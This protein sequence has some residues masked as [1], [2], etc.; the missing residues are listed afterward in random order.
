MLVRAAVTERPR[1]VEVHEFPMPEPAP[2]AVLMEVRYSGICGTD[3]HTFRGESKQYAGTAQR[4]RPD[5]PANLRARERRTG[6]CDWRG[7]AGRR[8]PAAQGRRPN[9]SWRKRSVRQPATSVA[10]GIP[11]IS[12]SALK[13]MGTVCIARPR[14]ICSGA[15]PNT[16]T[17]F[18]VRRSFACRTTCPTRS[19]SL[20]RSWP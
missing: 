14:R 18:P 20:P 15:G 5:L 12:A 3:K 4:A 16:C 1:C 9:R 10:M 11:I 6:R 8:R 17:F 13:T 19:P 2:G 7:G